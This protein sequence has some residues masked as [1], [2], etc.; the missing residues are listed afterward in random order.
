MAQ[1]KTNTKLDTGVAKP[2]RQSRVWLIGW[3]IAFCVLFFILGFNLS[4]SA[5]FSTLPL[6][7]YHTIVAVLISSATGVFGFFVFPWILAKIKYWIESLITQTVHSIVSNFWELQSRRIQEARRE[8]HKRKA[9]EE[10]QK[11]KKELENAIVLDTSVLV[12]GRIID[13]VKTG[14]FDSHLV[15]PQYVIHELQTIADSKDTIKRQRGRRGL[16]VIR[17]LKRYSKVLMPEVK[18]KDKEV[19]T[20]LVTFCKENKLKLMTLDFNLNKVASVSGVRALNLNDLINALKTVLLPGEVFKI[21]I[22]QAGK[23][24]EQGIGY[25]PDGTMVVVERAKD[26]VG[27]EVDTKVT[28]TI[29]SSAGRIIFCDLI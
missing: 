27:E 11:L 21:K 23:E 10:S 5:F 28:K 18:S 4:I 3:R 2:N 17:D 15:V 8:K 16:D 6:I 20:L 7:G 26:K 1:K 25:L 12:D 22:M 13:L 9:D 19:D 29:Q 24:K 14:F